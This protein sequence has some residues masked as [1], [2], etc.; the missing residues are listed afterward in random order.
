MSDQSGSIRLKQEFKSDE[1][2]VKIA[3]NDNMDIDAILGELN[4]WYRTNK[5]ASVLN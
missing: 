2:E 1:R 5:I 4:N 3:K